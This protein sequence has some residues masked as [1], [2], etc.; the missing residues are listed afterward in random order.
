MSITLVVWILTLALTTNSNSISV[1]L[2]CVFCVLKNRSRGSG[3]YSSIAEAPSLLFT[4]PPSSLHK[5]I[6]SLDPRF[7]H[8]RKLLPG[9]K[10]IVSLAEVFVVVD[11]V[12]QLP[13]LVD[14]L[15]RR[16]DGVGE[17]AG[18]AAEHA[19]LRHLSKQKK[20]I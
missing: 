8:A 14:L 20:P 4:T 12:G 1:Y 15:A 16:A 9:L 3:I 10:R 7:W 6:S 2:S 11:E 19:N 18:A 17:R 5:S 13:L